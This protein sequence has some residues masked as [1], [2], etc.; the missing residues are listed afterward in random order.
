MQRMSRSVS[1]SNTLL[2]NYFSPPTASYIVSVV[3]LCCLSLSF[4]PNAHA[5][6]QQKD[7]IKVKVLQN[8]EHDECMFMDEVVI[9]VKYRLRTADYAALSVELANDGMSFYE[10]ASIDI[11]RGKGKVIM[12]FDAGACATD[13]RVVVK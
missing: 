12:T 3:L 7:K 1:K 11:E 6:K 13:M 10:A 5:K 4:A 2:K 8:R 9:R